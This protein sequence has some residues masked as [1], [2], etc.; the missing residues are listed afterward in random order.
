M[1]TPGSRLGPLQTRILELLADM[2]PRW[3]PLGGAALVGFHLDHRT[4]RDLDLFFRPREELGHLVES[5]VERLRARGLS[6]DVIRRSQAFAQL[7]VTGPDESIILDLVAEPA[8][9]MAPPEEV[10]IGNVTILI[11]SRRELLAT[12]LCSLLHRSEI[13]DL[14]DVKELLG[15]GSAL[16]QG[17]TDAPLV[18]SGFS[19]MTLAWVLEGFD[20]AALASASDIPEDQ[21]GELDT[22]RS[23]L[24][25]QLLE[26]SRPG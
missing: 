21:A 18:D 17:L 23:H 10:R 5:I 11:A 15:A 1:G 12:K 22:F 20:I 14:M 4:T 2:E 19:A 24:V 8:E 3:T 26:H 7:K 13:R 9:P 25:N 16:P 6:I